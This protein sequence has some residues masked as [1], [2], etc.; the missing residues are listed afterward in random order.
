MSPGKYQAHGK[1]ERI[2]F[3]V[4]DCHLGKLLVAATDRGICAVTLGEDA[5][6]LEKK[7][8][9]QFPAAGDY[10]GRGL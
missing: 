8:R 5:K 1:G 3:T 9:E 7:L 10:G 2:R 6:D 4:A